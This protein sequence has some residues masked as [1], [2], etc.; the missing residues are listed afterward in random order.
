MAHRISINDG[1]TVDTG[2]PSKDELERLGQDGFRTM[3]N[4]RMVGEPNQ[5]L[6]PDAEGEVVRKPGLEYVPLP[7]PSTDLRSDQVG[8]FRERLAALPGPVLV[9]CAS[10]KRPGALPIL[11]VASQDGLPGADALARAHALGF[12]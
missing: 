6:S 7:V 12:D 10:G 9:H 5:P 4:L 11:H 8:R 3:A 2:Q 1:L